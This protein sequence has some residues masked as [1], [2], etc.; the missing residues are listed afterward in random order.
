MIPN[1]INGNVLDPAAGEIIG[2]RSIVVENDVIV[3]VLE[4]QPSVKPDSETA[5][6]AITSAIGRGQPTYS[7]STCWTST[8]VSSIVNQIHPLSPSGFSTMGIRTPRSNASCDE[9]IPSKVGLQRG[10]QPVGH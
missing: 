8:S 1:I 6:K 4:G 3:D 7:E 9:G 5:Y 2:E 10:R